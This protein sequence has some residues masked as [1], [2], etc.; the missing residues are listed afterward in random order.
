MGGEVPCAANAI[1]EAAAVNS[2]RLVEEAL[3]RPVK[4]LVGGPAMMR[5]LD[6]FNQVMAE[7]VEMIFARTNP[8]G[9]DSSKAGQVFELRPTPMRPAVRETVE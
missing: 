5:F 2:A 7:T 1:L 4:T 6:L 8:Y 3:E 9:I